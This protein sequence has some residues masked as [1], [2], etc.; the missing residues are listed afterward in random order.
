[1]VK[2]ELLKELLPLGWLLNRLL[3]FLLKKWLPL[4]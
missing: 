4:R 3:L 2:E 1:L